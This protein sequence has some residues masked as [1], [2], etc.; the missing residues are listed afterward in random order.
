MATAGGLLAVRVCDVSVIPITHCYYPEKR[1]CLP[2]LHVARVV[3]SKAALVYGR[4]AGG[5]R[6]TCAF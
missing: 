4:A 1:A 6:V 5:G 2:A 3:G